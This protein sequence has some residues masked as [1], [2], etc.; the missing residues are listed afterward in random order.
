MSEHSLWESLKTIAAESADR[1]MDISHYI[2]THPE[3][4]EKE[5]ESCHYLTKVLREAGFSVTCPYGTM[6]TAFRAEL[7]RGEG[8]TIAFLAEYDAL[9]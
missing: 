2:F 7:R 9:P 8:A 6:E 1:I 3:L 5:Y 4:G